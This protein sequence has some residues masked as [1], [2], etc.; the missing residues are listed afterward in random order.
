MATRK[1]SAAGTARKTVGKPRRKAGK[2]APSKSQRGTTASEIPCGIDTPAL[3][4]LAALIRELG[5]APLGGYLE[6]LGGAPILLPSVPL[7]AV[8]PTPFQRDLSPT[9]AKRLAE[10][11]DETGSFPCP[12]ILVRGGGGRPGATNRRPPPP[13]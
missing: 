3:A 9:H 4:S 12:P 1:K 13:G 11:I 2:L 7:A 10:K 5:G 6:P 8:Q